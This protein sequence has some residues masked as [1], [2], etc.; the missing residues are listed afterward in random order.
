MT[1]IP[2]TALLDQSQR[3]DYMEAAKDPL[4]D[5]LAYGLHQLLVCLLF[6][7]TSFP[8]ILFHQKE[9]VELF[10]SF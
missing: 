2:L 8:L 9:K 6:A 4:Q 3:T 10:T 1:L 5:G 7:V